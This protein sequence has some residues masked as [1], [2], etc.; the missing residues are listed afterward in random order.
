MFFVI[1]VLG[2]HSYIFHFRDCLSTSINAT[3]LDNMNEYFSEHVLEESNAADFFN[4]YVA[5]FTFG[6]PIKVLPP[7]NA[8]NNKS[9]VVIPSTMST[10]WYSNQV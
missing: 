4:E 1:L 6:P 9:V 5:G 10:V 7:S 3:N 8:T 2:I